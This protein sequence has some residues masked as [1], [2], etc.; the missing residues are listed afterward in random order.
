MSNGTIKS[1]VPR[2][3]DP[4]KFAQQGIDLKGEMAVSGFQRLV[5]AGVGLQQVY[6]DLQFYVDTDH[7]NERVVRGSVR[8][9]IDMQCQRCLDTVSSTIECT[10]ALGIVW[11]EESA[12]S[13]PS[14]LDPWIVGEDDADLCAMVEDELLLSLPYV[15]L[16]EEN[17]VDPS[18]MSDTADNESTEYT[19]P[20]QVLESLKGKIKK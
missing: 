11:S 18:T 13:L 6:L 2:Y 10:V 9:D 16:H 12:Q 14:Y 7:A 1:T 3:I 20:F 5:E 8:A 15:A 4:R 17:C 19:N